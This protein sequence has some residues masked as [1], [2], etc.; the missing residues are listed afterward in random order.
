MTI[1]VDSP[2]F[3]VLLT[4]VI[5]RTGKGQPSNAATP[6]K[7]IDLTPF[8]GTAGTIRTIKDINQPSGGF[9]ITFADKLM[10]DFADS[11]YALVEAQD[12][13][14]I[15]GSRR[16]QDYVGG[17]LPIIMTGFVSAVDRAESM[18]SDGEP[19]RT[20]TIQG[21]DFG[22]L[23]SIYYVYWQTFVATD[24]NFLATYDLQTI[25]GMDTGGQ[26]VSAFMTQLIKKIVNPKIE[27]MSV[28]SNTQIKPFSVNATV[29]DGSVLANM[30]NHVWTTPRVQELRRE[31]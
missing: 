3:Q 31:F 15:R 27:Q 25:L 30:W 12:Y 4:K 6:W 18:G 20:V 8:L 11:V 29:P 14:E 1:H 9:T 19:T 23:L 17:T 13:V 2:Q 16:A 28:F 21:H 7:N 10:P 24:Q 26:G 22:K 5:Q